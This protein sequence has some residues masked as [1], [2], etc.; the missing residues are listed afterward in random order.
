MKGKLAFRERG[1]QGIAE[2]RK[3][4]RKGIHCVK[5]KILFP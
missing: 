3:K 1:K 4:G 2:Q 5:R